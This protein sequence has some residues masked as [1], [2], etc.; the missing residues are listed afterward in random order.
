[1]KNNNI[2]KQELEQQF[3]ELFEKAQE[4]YPNIYE[5]VITYNRIVEESFDL[6]EY[7][8]LTNLP[9]TETTSN[10]VS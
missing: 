8:N 4:K 6:L 2:E 10:Q 3:N 1:M 7:M 9:P 5:S